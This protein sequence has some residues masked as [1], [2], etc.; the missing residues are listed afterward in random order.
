METYLYNHFPDHISSAHIA[1]FTS[2]KNAKVV[3]DPVTGISK[4]YGF[5]RFVDENEKNR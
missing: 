1:L 3:T 4:G 5:V 2:V